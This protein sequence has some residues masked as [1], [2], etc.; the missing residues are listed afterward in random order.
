MDTA[1][2]GD[3][4]IDLRVRLPR[5]TLEQSLLAEVMHGDNTDER[6]LREARV[7]VEG[8]RRRRRCFAGVRFHDPSWE[9]ILQLYVGSKEDRRIT[10]TR[11]CSL[12]GGSA[13]TA[14][15]HIEHLEA[16]GYI[17]RETDKNDRRCS[18]IMMLQP[19]IEAVDQWLDLQMV[20]AAAMPRIVPTHPHADGKRHDADGE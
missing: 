5:R 20:A 9:M 6:R 19:L 18:N 14:L 4:L 1:S 15:R 16:L 8:R 12:S 7:I 13:T 2:E 11:L 10:V 3:E 17:A